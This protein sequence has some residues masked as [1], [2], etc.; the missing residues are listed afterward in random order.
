MYKFWTVKIIRFI[1]LIFIFGVVIAMVFYPGGNIHNPEQIGYSFTNNFLSD[2]GGIK[3]R[4]GDSNIISFLFF[5]ASML[6]FALGGVGFLFVPRL[7]KTD[8]VNYILALIGSSFFFFGAFFFAGVGLTPHDL[9]LEEHIF[10]AI[11]GFRLLVPAAIF[12]FIVLLRS[13]VKNSYSLLTF[14]FLIS[15][16]SYVVFQ[17]IGESPLLSPE[18]MSRQATMQ[19]LITLVHLISI[20]SLSY[21]FNSQLKNMDIN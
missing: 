10:F 17:L 4:S 16:F 7:F 12:Y 15:T 21:A 2:L 13:P 1:P 11:N 5:N 8:K 18:A 20:F 9:Y 19:K 14:I 3:A 6:V